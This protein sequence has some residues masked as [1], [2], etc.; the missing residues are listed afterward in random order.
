[1]A[2]VAIMQPYLFP[3]IGYMNLVYASDKFV[4]YDD[5]NFINK[6]WINRN[7]IILMNK[8]YRFTLPLQ[9]KSQTK[10]IKDIEILDLKA[11]TEK[12]ISQIDISYKNSSNKIAV[13]TYVQ[14]VLN[15]EKKYI[16][17]L[18]ITSI[19]NFFKYI[20]VE[21]EFLISSKDFSSTKKL[22]GIE[23][24]ISISKRLNCE[25]YLNL[26]GGL[27]LYKKED[28]KTKDVQ[29]KFLKPSLMPYKQSN[30]NS[31]IFY[32]ALSIIDV[33]M[34]QSVDEI[35]NQLKSYLLL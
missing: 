33:M 5:V 27:S 16:S 10:L 14:N 25:N 30:L 31:D 17:D 23:R 35:H 12:F 26:I 28:F 4:F 6:G 20:G 3:Y 7:R 15:S 29:L 34:N 19:K 11:F 21:K 18:A 22:H 24:L 1:M 32:P 2:S 8:P 13:L 9:A